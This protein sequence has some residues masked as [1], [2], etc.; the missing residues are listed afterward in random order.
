M[1]ILTLTMNPT[2]DINSQVD[3]VK[4]DKK[5]RCKQPQY[6]P[7]GGG[8]NVSR[9][10]RKLGGS[11]EAVYLSGGANGK[12]LGQLLEQE[13]IVHSQV[14]IE[15]LTRESFHIRETSGNQQF[16]FTMPG[17]EVL[18]EEWEKCLQQIQTKK[19]K[20]DY[21]VAS[22]SLPPGVPNDFYARLAQISKNH[23]IQIILDTTG[24]P[25]RMAVEEG[26]FLIKPN[27]REVKDLIGKDVE[28]E[29]ELKKVAVDILKQG[30][31][32][33]IVISLGA[34]GA[35]VVTSD[36]CEHLRSPTV[37]IKSKVGA[38]DS[39]IA[40]IVLAL[41][42]GKKLID[43]VKYGVAAGAAAV[44]TPGTELCRLDDVENIY[45]QMK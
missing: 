5:L 38:G 22:G 29:I 21:I 26:V 12:L 6:Q 4:P 41:P 36:K 18:K 39:M 10:I 44:M 7:G 16:R 37:P 9:A 28:N 35:F 33:V 31:S 23:Q 2:I 30:N 24:E 15:N 1:K 25:L 34:G 45:Q 13:G 14:V 27:M 20:P 11:S 17:P 32:E 19:S 40:G 3:R 42:R 8:L 43:A